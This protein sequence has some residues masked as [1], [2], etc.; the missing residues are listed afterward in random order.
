[1]LRCGGRVLFKAMVRTQQWRLGIRDRQRVPEQSECIR[2]AFSTRFLPPMWSGQAVVIGRL[3][4]GIPPE[5][6]RLVGQ[7]VLPQSEK[8]EFMDPLPG[9]RLALR[10]EWYIPILR[11]P[12]AEFFRVINL[13]LGIIQRGPAIARALKNEDVDTLIG[14]SGDVVDPPA[15]YLAARI[16][17]CKLFLYFFDDYTEQWWAEPR[18]RSV[19]RRV[20]RVI[21][22][23]ADGLISPNEYMQRELRRR[24]DRESFIVRNPCPWTAFA[25]TME[26]LA[27]R[28]GEFKLVFTGAVYHLNY[29]ILQT[30]LKAIAKVEHANVKLHIYTAQPASELA[31]QGL[32]SPHI[33]IHPHVQPNEVLALQRNAD[34]LL[35]PF[36]FR[37][38]ASGIVRSAA[39]AKLAD[40]LLTGRPIMALCPEDSFLGWYLSTHR[41]GLVVPRDDVD[42][43]ASQIELLIGDSRRREEFGSNAIERAHGDFDPLRAQTDLLRAIGFNHDRVRK[44]ATTMHGYAGL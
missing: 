1:M 24:C 12:V 13:F 22:A 3:L 41:C 40:Y 10:R 21:S 8:S 38:E 35:I 20:E 29:D 2:F 31:R 42:L 27:E 23:R 28:D 33:E 39:T 19:V 9:K 43:V 36:S 34:I 25:T 7:P 16:L 18:L 15:A 4:D 37:P 44:T 17:G 30:V 6:Y 26:P 5:C 14:C 32:I 11:S